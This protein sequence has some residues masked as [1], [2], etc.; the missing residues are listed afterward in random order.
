[1]LRPR[2]TGIPIV[3]A[4]ERAVPQGPAPGD[5]LSPTQ[6]FSELTFRP[7]ARL[8]LAHFRNDAGLIGAADLARRAMVE[9]PESGRFG[10]WP[11]RKKQRVKKPRRR[12]PLGTRTRRTST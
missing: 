7:E 9:P 11:R 8:E 2:C 5:H 6:P 4:P 12:E 3:P 10:F 1:M